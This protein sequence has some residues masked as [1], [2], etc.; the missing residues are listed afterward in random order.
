MTAATVYNGNGSHSVYTF[1]YSSMTSTATST[2]VRYSRVLTFING[3]TATYSG[4]LTAYYSYSSSVI[5]YMYMYL[6]D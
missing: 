6:D 2:S 3:T 5:S 4:T 1:T